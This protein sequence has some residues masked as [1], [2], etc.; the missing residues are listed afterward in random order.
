MSDSK[1]REKNFQQKLSRKLGRAK[2]V[3][4]MTQSKQF[5]PLRPARRVGNKLAPKKKR[6]APVPKLKDR[7]IDSIREQRISSLAKTKV[8]LKNINEYPGQS[9]FKR[10]TRSNIYNLRDSFIDDSFGSMGVESILSRDIP[11]RSDDPLPEGTTIPEM[12]QKGT[13]PLSPTRIKEGE[14]FD[15]KSSMRGSIEDVLIAE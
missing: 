8:R 11:I 9:K 1:P 14:F 13:T 6:L 5:G 10:G 2:M 3:E 7:F 4:R 12:F 15:F